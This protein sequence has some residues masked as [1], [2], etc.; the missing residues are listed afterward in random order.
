MMK[1]AGG[2]LKEF[3]LSAGLERSHFAAIEVGDTRSIGIART[4]DVSECGS[5]PY[6]CEVRLA[7]GHAWN[8]R[9]LRREHD[10]GGNEGDYEASFHVHFFSV[11]FT[12]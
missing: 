10:C 4:D 8:A 3:R 7:A 2:R 12:A 11:G 1:V 9:R 5:G 6:A